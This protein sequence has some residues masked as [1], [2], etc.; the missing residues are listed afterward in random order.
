MV[1]L[2]AVIPERRRGL[3][4]HRQDWPH[5]VFRTDGHVS[6]VEGSQ[7]GH[8]VAERFARVRERGLN[9]GVVLR[10]EMPLH[11]VSDWNSCAC[12]AVGEGAVLV[13]DVDDVD[14]GAA[15][16]RCCPRGA[17]LHLRPSTAGENK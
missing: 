15:G 9:D 16:R 1:A 10:V 5:S 7:V 17:A 8:D 3:H 14:F 6:R 11:H 2:R 4:H 13:G 12:G